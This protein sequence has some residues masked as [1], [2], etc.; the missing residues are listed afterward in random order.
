MIG[1]SSGH[2]RAITGRSDLS[3]PLAQLGLGRDG[4]F[5]VIARSPIADD[6]AFVAELAARD[7]FVLPGSTIALPG[8]FRISLTGSDA[9]V[10]A[11]IPRFAAAREAA[12]SALS[13]IASSRRGRPPATA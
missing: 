5:Y 7:V 10:E 3:G 2:D 1:L 8:W 9:M 4:T 11:S 13:A 6:Q 12:L